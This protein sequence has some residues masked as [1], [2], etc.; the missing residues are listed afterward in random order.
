MISVI[1]NWSD[2]I[3]QFDPLHGWMISLGQQSASDPPNEPDK[4]VRVTQM[5]E[6]IL[7][8]L[9]VSHILNVFC[10]HVEDLCA[11]SPS[12][13]VTGRWLYIAD[14]LSRTP[15]LREGGIVRI[16]LRGSAWSMLIASDPTASVV[17]CSKARLLRFGFV[18]VSLRSLI[19]LVVT[20]CKLTCIAFWLL[21]SRSFL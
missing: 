13:Q 10:T 21:V 16:I 5:V 9:H 11:A 7:L 17:T 3:D 2:L 18:M 1:E 15:F 19:W 20:Q 8:S 12:P 14:I 4:K 6:A